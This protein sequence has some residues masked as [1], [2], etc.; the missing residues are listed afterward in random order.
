MAVTAVREIP[1]RS[2]S[3]A[4]VRPSFVRQLRTWLFGKGECDTILPSYVSLLPRERRKKILENDHPLPDAG[5]CGAAVSSAVNPQ[6]L[7]EPSQNGL[8]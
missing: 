1:A 2:A 8:V 7:C 6:P 4:W 5:S 3:C